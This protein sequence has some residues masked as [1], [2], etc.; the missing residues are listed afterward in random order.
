[1]AV[2]TYEAMGYF[3][4][5]VLDIALFKPVKSWNFLGTVL[6]LNCLELAMEV[7]KGMDDVGGTISD[8]LDDVD[9]LVEIVDKKGDEK[10]YEM[11]MKE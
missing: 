6:F 7:V 1:M 3:V 4:E 8:M 2:Q 10:L 11:D 9:S 5:E